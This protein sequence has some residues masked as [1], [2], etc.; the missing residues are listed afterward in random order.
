MDAN[1][2]MSLV[3]QT[4]ADVAQYSQL[5]LEKLKLRLLD[6]FA[7]LLNKIFAALVMV[8][9]V[10]FAVLSLAFAL[11]WW[12]GTRIGSPSLAAVIVAG[13]FAVILL[14]VYLLR[15]RLVVNASVKMLAKLMFEND[16]D[17]EEED[18]E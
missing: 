10:C 6:N 13:V 2:E 14:A 4:V 7:T 5:Q 12:I 1:G 15:R 17:R 18:D 9:V 3:E 16:K 8:I 11:A